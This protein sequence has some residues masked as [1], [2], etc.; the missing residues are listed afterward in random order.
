MIILLICCSLTLWFL[1]LPSSSLALLS[2]GHQIWHYKDHRHIALPTILLSSLCWFWS[3][4]RLRV[5]PTELLI[6]VKTVASSMVLLSLRDGLQERTGPV[7]TLVYFRSILLSSWRVWMIY[8]S[9]HHVAHVRWS[10]CKHLILMEHPL[11]VSRN[12]RSLNYS[13][14]A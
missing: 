7:T 5:H 4:L 1:T 12:R 6:V 14:F 13:C 9:A 8:S 2:L 3:S 10:S 11:L